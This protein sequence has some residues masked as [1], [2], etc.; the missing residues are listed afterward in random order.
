MELPA[1]ARICIRRLEEAGYAAYAVGGC[2]R[3][4]LWGRT[5]H[6][7]DLCTAA[8]PA[9][10]AQ[11]FADFPLVRAGEKHGTVGVIMDGQV[12][13]ITTFRTEGG[14][15]DS[16]HPDWVRFVPSLEED[17]ARRDFTV[18]AMA[19]SP[20]RGLQ[21][22][23]GGWQDLTDRVLRAVGDPDL[24]FSEDALRILRG[25]R[26]SVRYG[27]VPE[28][29]TLRAMEAL[30]PTMERLAKERIFDELCKLLPTV[31][32][33]DL[34]RFGPILT[35]V[36]PELGPCMGFQQHNPHH[37]FDVYTHTA[38]VVEHTPPTL[39][40]RWASL[41]HDIGKPATF[42]LDGSGIGH[43]Y[44][45]AQES[46]RLADAILLRLKSPTALRRQVVTLIAQ[47]M[48]PLAPD[49]RLLQ[50]RMSRLGTETVR[51]LLQ[52]QKADF[53]G[54]PGEEQDRFSEIE[55]LITQL[56]AEN[57]CLQVTDLAIGGRELLALG[58]EGPAIGQALQGL[59]AKVLEGSLP[60]SREALLCAIRKEIGQ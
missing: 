56:E 37:I 33:R 51:Q 27:L 34:I 6:D 42:T 47:H 41:L 9:Q 30:A 19:W 17:L 15:G 50:K 40:L 39:P 28:E 48:T 23:F 8:T 31:R 4:W 12:I 49:K 53:G 1:S 45:H 36:L 24:R 3:D 52:L 26:F 54:K 22:P 59:L 16:R 20:T 38:Q 2:V 21:D 44:G 57:A 10:T 29:K 14:Y 60:N 7:F 46:A 43:F 32:A 58:L 11:V 35:Q 25:V 18:N 5:P 55:A 13:E